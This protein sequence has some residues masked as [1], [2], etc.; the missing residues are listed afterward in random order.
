[1]FAGLPNRNG[2]RHASEIAKLSLDLI[3][4][5]GEVEMPLMPGRSLRIRVGLHSG[6][7]EGTN[8]VLAGGPHEA[9]PDI[10][11][12]QF[13]CRLSQGKALTKSQF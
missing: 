7:L 13:P 8:R 10:L 5:C 6:R 12:V 2:S 1:M 11:C 9:S 3:A 4:S